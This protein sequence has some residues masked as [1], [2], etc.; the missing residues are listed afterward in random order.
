MGLDFSEDAGAI[1]VLVMLPFS[2]FRAAM[3]AQPSVTEVEKMIGLVHRTAVIN[4]D[5]HRLLA[6][7]SPDDCLRSILE[8]PW[9]RGLPSGALGLRLAARCARS[10]LG[11][12]HQPFVYPASDKDH[13]S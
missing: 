8:L 4:G 5:G 3:F 11:P 10:R 6:G 13:P 12:Y 1:A 7:R 9:C 2:I